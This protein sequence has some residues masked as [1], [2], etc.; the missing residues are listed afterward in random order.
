[1]LTARFKVFTNCIIPEGFLLEQKQCDRHQ[2]VIRACG[3]KRRTHVPATLAAALQRPW[4][5]AAYCSLLLTL[6][7]PID[8]QAISFPTSFFSPLLSDWLCQTNRGVLFFCFCFLFWNRILYTQ[9]TLE[10]TMYL[11][12]SFNACSSCFHPQ[13]AEIKPFKKPFF[14]Y[15]VSK[16]SLIQAS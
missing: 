8:N 14:T 16:T 6:F 13:D 7:I 4:S 3:E 11:K 5:I 9:A 2:V 1:M 10:L 15:F 12:I